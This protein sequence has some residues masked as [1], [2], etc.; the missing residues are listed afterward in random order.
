MNNTEKR[1]IETLQEKWDELTNL[2]ENCGFDIEDICGGF[3][4]ARR[5]TERVTGKKVIIDENNVVKFN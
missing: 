1:M 5:F 3:D 2:A 4:T